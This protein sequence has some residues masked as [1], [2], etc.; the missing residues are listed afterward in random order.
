MSTVKTSKTNDHVE[1]YISSIAGGAMLGAITGN[2]I[3][4]IIGG[5]V[6]M[7]IANI[8]ANRDK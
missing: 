1:R 6:G 4:I 5:I 2:V 7:Y 8:L 3:W